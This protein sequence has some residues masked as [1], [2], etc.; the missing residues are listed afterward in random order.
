VALLELLAFL[1]ERSQL[2]L[3]LA[4]VVPLEAAPPRVVLLAALVVRQQTEH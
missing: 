1:R 2:Q 3:L 4:L